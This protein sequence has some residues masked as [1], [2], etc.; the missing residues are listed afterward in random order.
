MTTLSQRR[1]LTALTDNKQTCRS[2]R[3]LVLFISRYIVGIVVGQSSDHRHS[4]G[5]EASCLQSLKGRQ[6]KLITLFY[7][8]LTNL[9][10]LHL[11]VLFT[12]LHSQILTAVTLSLVLRPDIVLKIKGH[13]HLF[14]VD[15]H[16]IQKIYFNCEEKYNNNVH[17]LLQIY[18]YRS[19][20]FFTWILQVQI[21]WLTVLF[22]RSVSPQ[23]KVTMHRGRSSTN[24]LN[25]LVLPNPFQV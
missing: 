12:Y 5:R 4:V 2:C 19:L 14:Q 23:W 10:P 18:E 13:K 24:K 25:N 3:Y 15:I 7:L 11:F 8:T 21:W 6:G 17:A 1:R 16:W 9:R 22:G 20:N